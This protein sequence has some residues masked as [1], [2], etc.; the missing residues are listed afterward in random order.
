VLTLAA[1]AINPEGDSGNASGRASRQTDVTMQ[2]R[3]AATS[4]NAGE[5]A[6]LDCG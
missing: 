4:G 5:S 1:A 2:I 6:E 3:G